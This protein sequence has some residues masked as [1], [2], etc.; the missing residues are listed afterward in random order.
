MSCLPGSKPFRAHS[1]FLLACWLQFHISVAVGQNVDGLL[2]A[3]K[4]IR[5]MDEAAVVGLVPMQSGLQYV[6]CPNCTAGRQE[7]Q[8]EWTIERPDVVVCAFCKHE[9][10]SEKYPMHE[11]VVVHTPR[12]EQARFA[13]WANAEGYRYFFQARRD[14]EVRRYLA[15]QTR[16]LAELY[17]ATGDKFHARRA[18]V[19]LDRFAEVFP[20]WCYHYDYPFRQKEIYDGDVSP[21][22]FRDGYRTARWNWWAYS[23]IPDELVDAYQMLKESGAFEDLSKEKGVDV[24]R[25]IEA[26]LLRNAGDQVLANRDDYTNMSPNAWQD[27]V[28]LG[29]VIEE[30]KYVHEVVRRFRKLMELQFFYDGFW[31]EGAPSYGRQTVGNLNVVLRSLQGYSD[32]A[33]Y[34]DPVDGTRF[35]DLHLEADFPLLRQAQAALDRMVLPDGRLVPVHDTWSVAER[36]RPPTQWSSY[37]I[38]ALGHSCLG[39]GDGQT[40]TE[41]HLTWS[42]GYGHQHADMLSLMLY[43]PGGEV[44]S[45]LGYTHTAYRSWTL[46]T[47]AHN[48]VV[49]DG[50]SQ[51]PGSRSA[52]TDGNLRF[53]DL[54]HPAVQVVSVDGVRAYPK[55]A[56]KYERTLVVV[57]AGQGRRYAVD[58]FEVVGGTTHDYFLHGSADVSTQVRASIPMIDRATLLPAGMD[59]RATVNEGESGKAFERHYPYGFLAQLKSAGVLNKQPVRIDFSGESP[60]D[61]LRVTVIPEPESELVV[62]QNPSIRGAGED[63]SRLEDFHRP[64]AM[65]RHTASK[66]GSRF[67]AVLEPHGAEPFIQSVERMT[68][69]AGALSLRITLPD[70]IDVVMLGSGTISMTAQ[71]GSLKAPVRF[72]GDVGVF[73]ITGEGV[74]QAYALGGNWKSEGWALESA[75]SRQA[76]LLSV[77]SDSF[78]IETQEAIL[79]KPGEVVRLVTAD[80]WVYPYHVQ[81]V[82]RESE[83][84]HAK[85]ML[86][87]SPGFDFD[88]EQRMLQFRSFP[89][90]SH[91]GS[92]HVEWTPSAYWKA[93]K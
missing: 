81:S 92:V 35:D 54:T 85:L 12:G 75:A 71:S 67:V 31:S 19:I 90:R 68:A 58:L 4:Q 7:R 24:A 87:E 84:S 10:P 79:P 77:S 50:H 20:N 40:R 62:G 64:F 44:L 93:E 46:A 15:W 59:W 56:T 70:R 47:A 36:R 1:L 63:D 42:G 57:D 8:L 43:A 61:G 22:E 2:K 83:S 80:G 48:T 65:L 51:E 72:D 88:A 33:G 82:V 14:D 18:A 21:S 16:S 3:T 27:L 26:D 69:T 6:G 74:Q 28:K 86:A 34:V 41:F 9:Y 76:K 5:E 17:K 13:Y 66:K 11:A 29:R 52:P 25:R 30:P 89:Q 23:D 73:S 39:I 91:Q 45:D 38:P 37:L 60:Q 53:I 55:L 78:I 32:P 49:I